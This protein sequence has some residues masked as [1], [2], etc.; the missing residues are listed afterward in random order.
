MSDSVLDYLHEHG[1]DDGRIARRYILTLKMIHKFI[2]A[3]KINQNIVVDTKVLKT[4]TID[5]FVD[6]ARI[7]EFHP[8]PKTSP[9]KIYGYMA[10]WLLK[11]KPLQVIKEFPGSEFINEL[12]VTAY[13]VSSILAEKT[14][15]GNQCSPNKNFIDFQLLLFY[16]LKYRP[17]TQQSLELIIKAFF[18]GHEV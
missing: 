12:F 11:R 2:T 1:Y 9:E 17:L 3:K 6:V 7:K 14:L 10:Y 13:I 4:A 8:I 5:H 18:C 15:K 16:H